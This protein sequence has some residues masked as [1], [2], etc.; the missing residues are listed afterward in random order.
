[1]KKSLFF[2]IV[3]KADFYSVASEIKDIS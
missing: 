2:G 1:M 3:F